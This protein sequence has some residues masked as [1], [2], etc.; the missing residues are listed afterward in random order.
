MTP[1]NEA[2]DTLELV[3]LLQV[4]LTRALVS[5]FS[6]HTASYTPS[7]AH[8]DALQ[9]TRDTL[10]K[11]DDPDWREAN[12]LTIAQNWLELMGHR[13]CCEEHLMIGGLCA[14][15]LRAAERLRLSPQETLDWDVALL[16]KV[17]VNTSLRAE[18][19]FNKL[20]FRSR[21]GSA[22]FVPTA[23]E[24]ILNAAFGRE[25]VAAVQ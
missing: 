8:H 16:L 25:S 18:W 9:A 24:A 10:A 14:L 6:V 20:Q 22:H 2:I 21:H 23:D 17:Y 7:H 5:A 15:R 3:N 12:T 1:Q 19:H 4:E 13:I 11:A